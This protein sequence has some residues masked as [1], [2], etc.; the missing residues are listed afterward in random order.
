MCG[1]FGCVCFVGVF[2]V[3]FFLFAVCIYDFPLYLKFCNQISP[4]HKYK[5]IFVNQ[6]LLVPLIDNTLAE[7]MIII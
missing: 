3:C 7:F 5:L 1:G 2:W 4:I 6:E